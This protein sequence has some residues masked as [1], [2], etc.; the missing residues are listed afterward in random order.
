[1]FN[2]IANLK[3]Y[4]KYTVEFESKHIPKS[5]TT[6]LTFQTLIFFS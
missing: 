5:T 2:Y 6:F 4:E 1:M 3:K